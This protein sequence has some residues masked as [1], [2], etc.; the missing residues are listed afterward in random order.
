MLAVFKNLKD[1][2]STPKSAGLNKRD[3]EIFIYSSLKY[4][5]MLLS[6]IGIKKEY[7]WLK[8]F[9][10]KEKINLNLKINI[11][12]SNLIIDLTSM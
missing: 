4:S 10:F 5:S 2:A 8:Y 12:N 7:I 1:I 6:V 11:N 9:I 3:E